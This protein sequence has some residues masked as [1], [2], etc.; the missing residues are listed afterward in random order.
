MRYRNLGETDIKISEIGFGCWG[1]GGFVDGLNSYGETSDDV[2]LRALK[3]AFDNGINFFDTANIYGLGHSEELIGRAFGK[4]RDRVVIATK[5]GFDSFTKRMDFTKENIEKSINQSLNR[6]DT[7]YIDLLQLHDPEI[8]IEQNLDLLDCLN[9]QVKI[10]KIKALGVS[11][12]NPMQGLKFMKEP[13]QSIQCNFN[14]I[15]IR[16]FEC[17][18][19]LNA[20]QNNVSIIARTPL[21][22]GFLSGQVVIDKLKEGDHRLKWPRE[23]LELWGKSARLFAKI[24]EKNNMTS[25]ELAI[26][27]CVSFDAVASVIP[28]MLTAEEA[29]QNSNISNF[30]LIEEDVEEIINLSKANNSL[31]S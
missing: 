24:A 28:G 21:A 5:C 25:S 3:T 12:K 9:N 22:F 20:L 2:S 26:K 4:C 30:V 7:D 29:I 15:D 10:G 13:W 11:V 17:G 14:M 23:Q 1:I 6:L 31:V 16:A 27:F 8:T 18:L 19:F